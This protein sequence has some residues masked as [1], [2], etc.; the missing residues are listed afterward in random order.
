MNQSAFIT[1]YIDYTMNDILSSNKFPKIDIMYGKETNQYYTHINFVVLY[2]SPKY[3]LL[4]P[5]I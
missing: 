2:P 4:I 3:P 1:W 5:L